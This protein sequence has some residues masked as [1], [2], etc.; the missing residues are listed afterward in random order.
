MNPYALQGESEL[1]Q[2]PYWCK[3]H[4]HRIKHHMHFHICLCQLE[5]R[6]WAKKKKKI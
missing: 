4:T 5:T 3:G 2:H 1:K 6:M